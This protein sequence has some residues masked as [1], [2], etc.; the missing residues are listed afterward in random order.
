MFFL[1]RTL[2]GD[3]ATTFLLFSNVAC[4]SSLILLTLA[5]GFCGFSF[6]WTNIYLKIFTS[7]KVD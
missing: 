1:V 7:I 5:Y 2:I 6:W 4:I 3:S